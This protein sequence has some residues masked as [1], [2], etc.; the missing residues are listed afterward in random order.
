MSGRGQCLALVPAPPIPRLQTFSHRP[1][2]LRRL[3]HPFVS[4]PRLR[5]AV[6][7]SSRC[8]GFSAVWRGDPVGLL[9]F[10]RYRA[11]YTVCD[12]HL[13]YFRR[14]NFLPVGGSTSPELCCPGDGPPSS[15]VIPPHARTRRA[16]RHIF[17]AC[18]PRLG[19]NRRIPRRISP[20]VA[21]D[22]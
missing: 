9:L 7:G 15:D 16:L 10:A 2:Q 21:L 12:I 11:P 17:D 22:G 14:R 13:Q 19:R 6:S 4:F 1:P 5:P 18:E 3:P 20:T 8:N